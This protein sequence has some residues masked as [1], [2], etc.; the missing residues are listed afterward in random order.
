MSL[1]VLSV[2]FWLTVVGP[3]SVGGAEHILLQIDQGLVQRG[4][5]SLVIARPESKISGSLIPTISI[6]GPVSHDAWG[7]AHQAIRSAI[8]EAVRKYPVDL[9]HLHGVDFADY[10]PIEDIPV[11]VTL[12]L[13]LHWYKPSALEVN[14]PHT[15]FHCVS[16]SQRE[17]FPQNLPMLPDIENGVSSELFRERGIRKGQFAAAL[18]RICPEKGFELALSACRKTDTAM[19]LAGRVFPF[20]E[21]QVYFAEK[22]APQL[23]GQRRY[24]GPVGMKG[25]CRLLSSAQCVIVPSVA[26]ETSSLVAREALACGTPVVAFA[27]GALPEVVRH[28]ETGFL[29]RDAG[30]LPDAIGAAR[31]LDSQKCRAEARRRFTPDRMVERYI[32]TYRGI[33]E[34]ACR[35]SQAA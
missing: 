14:R 5:Q 23:D 28:G 10:L 8:S 31:H 33:L 29:L 26:P 25:K 24:I 1:S 4:H 35:L 21:H 6:D 11:L 20:R 9:V 34:G 13:P 18:G 12:H 27:T 7:A 30:E 3:E 19:L 2:A 32:A 22:I 15:F 16:H 17:T